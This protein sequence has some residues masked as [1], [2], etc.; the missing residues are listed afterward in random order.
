V[1]DINDIKER[2]LVSFIGRMGRRDFPKAINDFITLYGHGFE[3]VTFF[4]KDYFYDTEEEYG[5]FEPSTLM[6]NVGN[7]A[8]SL[9]NNEELIYIMPY[10]H[11]YNKVDEYIRVTYS[12]EHPERLPEVSTLMERLYDAFNL[13]EKDPGIWEPYTVEKPD[14]IWF[15]GRWV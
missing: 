13:G 14:E 7:H 4:F 11:F 8:I 10:R 6:L 5:L 12:K 3:D 15:L 9:P 1:A 2:W